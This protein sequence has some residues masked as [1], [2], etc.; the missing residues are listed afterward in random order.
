MSAVSIKKPSAAEPFFPRMSKRHIIVYS[1]RPP[2]VVAPGG[3]FTPA[4]ASPLPPVEPR[5]SGAFTS[6]QLPLD[7]RLLSG[8]FVRPIA[9]GL[10][11]VNEGGGV[12]APELK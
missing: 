4:A 12:L 9:E 8:L 1:S 10:S 2:L 7:D 11:P 3:A 6:S 5:F